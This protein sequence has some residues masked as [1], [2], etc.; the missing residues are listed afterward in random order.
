MEAICS[1]ETLV[2]SQPTT[3]SYFPEDDT[4]IQGVLFVCIL[5]TEVFV[6]IVIIVVNIKHNIKTNNISLIHIC[7][8]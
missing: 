5:L 6:S 3:R 2:N 8:G 7:V 4:L 1:S